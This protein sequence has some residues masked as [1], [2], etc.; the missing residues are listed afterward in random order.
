MDEVGPPLARLPHPRFRLPIAGDLLSV[1]SSKPVQREMKMADELGGIYERKIFGHRLVVVSDPILVNQVNNEKVWAKFLGLPHRKLRGIAGDGLFTAFNSEPNWQLG[2][3]VLGPAFNKAAMR[4]HHKSMQR[5]ID[6]LLTTWDNSPASES[7]DAYEECSKLAFDVIGR[8]A[9]SHD[10]GTFD[11]GVPFAEAIARALRYVNRSSNDVPVVRAVTGRSASRQH[12]KDLA[13]IRDTVDSLV[14]SRMPTRRSGVNANSDLLQHMFETVDP[15]TGVGLS[16]ENIKNQIITFLVA[17]NE[18]TASTM[19]FALHFLSRDSGLLQSLRDE[20]EDVSPDG[21]AV[22]FD[23]V[24][25]LRRVRRVIDETLRLWPAAPGYFRKARERGP[26][27]L[28]G[29]EIPEGWVFVLLPQ[30]HRSASWGA[31]ARSFD[32]DRFMVG[33]TDNAPDRVYK[34]WGTG[35]RACIGRQFALHEAVLALASIV[36]RYDVVPDDSYELDVRE[37]IT[38]RPHG[39]RLRL[40]RCV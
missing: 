8:C 30:V 33:R 7:V 22:E 37:A 15:T 16:V 35:L 32:P 25:K 5:S 36:R 10:F 24:P 12:D 11:G 38:L 26:A 9:L 23:D 6:G 20:V 28:G 31:D 14:E 3:A 40:S 21:G 39:V 34:P 4:R 29:Y 19:A 2:H 18:T 27:E 13:L 1:D 17:G